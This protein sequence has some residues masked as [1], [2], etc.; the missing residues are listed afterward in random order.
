[1]GWK[2]IGTSKR[3]CKLCHYYFQ[4]HQSDVRHRS[5]HGNVYVNWRVPDVPKAQCPGAEEKS[6]GMVARVI[7]RIRKDAFDLVKKR[8]KPTYRSH[9]S[10]TSSARLTL[11][12][13]S[14]AD[15]AASRMA[16][17]GISDDDDENEGGAML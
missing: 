6:Q 14:D 4:E 11:Q 15:D 8:V 16:V 7:I 13:T 10:I 5:S 2:Y 9:D 17:F 12:L 1:Q 3:T